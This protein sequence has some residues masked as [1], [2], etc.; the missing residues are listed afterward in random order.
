[1]FTLP[2][3]WNVIISTLV[4]ALAAWYIRRSLEA[5][6]I[7]KSMTRG[8]IVFVLAYVVATA[9]GDLVDWAQEK[10]Y[11]PQATA[12]STEDIA[13]LMKAAGL[14]SESIQSH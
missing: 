4:F 14:S 1:M 13:K 9:S 10:I 3:I 2:S 5:H 6:D 8:L 11:G 7:P 12:Q